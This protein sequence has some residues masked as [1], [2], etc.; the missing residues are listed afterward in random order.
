[1]SW[2]ENPCQQLKPT[3]TKW[4]TCEVEGLYIAAAVKNFEGYIIQSKHRTVILSDSK[5]CVDAYNKLL[6]GQFS[7]NARLSTFLSTVSRHHVEIQHLAGNLN[8]TAD[9]ASRNPNGI[10]HKRAINL[11]RRCGNLMSFKKR[12]IFTSPLALLKLIVIN[13]CKS[14]LILGPKTINMAKRC[15]NTDYSW[16]FL[17]GWLS[18]LTSNDP[19]TSDTH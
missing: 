6:R 2:Q 13:P 10:I 7:S 5:P 19:Y 11:T 3:Y 17:L 9:F 8:L 14:N 16:S 15:W 12:L 18:R 1:M 4:F